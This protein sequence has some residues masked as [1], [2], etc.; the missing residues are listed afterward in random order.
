LHFLTQTFSF[1]D[2]LIKHLNQ[3]IVSLKR[4][5]QTI[6]EECSANDRLGQD[7]FAKLA[8]KVRPSEAS[9]FRTHVDAVGNITSLLLSLSERLAQTESSLETRQQERVGFLK[10]Y[11]PKGHNLLILLIIPL[12]ARWNQSGICCTSSWRRRSVSN[13]T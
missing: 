3:K 7:L 5:Q 11:I 1:Q 6:S 4:E 9:K 8:E 10:N 13:R 2:E 12:R